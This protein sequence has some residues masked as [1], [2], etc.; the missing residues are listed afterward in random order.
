VA[1]LIYN[2]STISI[3]VF[4]GHEHQHFNAMTPHHSDHRMLTTKSVKSI[5]VHRYSN[6]KKKITRTSVFQIDEHLLTDSPDR[7]HVN[8]NHRFIFRLH[9]CTVPAKKQQQP[10][11]YN[12]TYTANNKTRSLAVAKRS[13]NCCVGLFWPNVTERQYF[14]DITSIFNNCDITDLESYWI[15]WNNAK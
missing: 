2:N 11:C 1:V 14:A 8:T 10:F 5:F 12:Y 13:C 7:Q 6:V 15:Q 4:I 9:G 3:M